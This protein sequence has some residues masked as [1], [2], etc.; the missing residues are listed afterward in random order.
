ME[1]IQ[2]IKLIFEGENKVAH[3]GDGSNLMDKIIRVKT[4]IEQ[5]K[6]NPGEIFV[7]MDLNKENP[8]FRQSV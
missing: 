6:G 1:S 3:I 4:I 5:E 8:I 2:N 7:N